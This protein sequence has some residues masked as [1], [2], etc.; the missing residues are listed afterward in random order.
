VTIAAANVAL[1]DPPGV[2]VLKVSTAAEL[3]ATCQQQAA[4]AEVV[5]MAAAVADFRPAAPADHKLKKTASQAPLT[6]ELE[7]TA[8]ILS[9]LAANRL[10]GQTL[11]GFA[12]EHG[13]GALEYGREKLTRKHLDAVVV[14][15]I[16][17]S[18]IGFDT[19][20]N[21]VVIIS[22]D[23]VET[24]VALAGKDTVADEILNQVSRLRGSGETDGAQRP[25]RF[26]GARG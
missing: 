18:D 4:D 2:T 20:D 16:S 10:A 14:N 8:D 1:P 6:I 13:D 26:S 9:G 3:E 17:R 15:D 19:Q 24:H 21:E 11:V 22:R 23:G 7:P 25:T 12:A 5:L